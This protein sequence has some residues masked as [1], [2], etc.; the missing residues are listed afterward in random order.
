MWQSEVIDSVKPMV[1]GPLSLLVN[2][3]GSL[4]V[5]YYDTYYY[6]LRHALKTSG[7]WWVTESIKSNV[8]N[9]T[10]LGMVHD[11]AGNLHLIFNPNENVTYVTN[12][13]G[14]WTS[15]VISKNEATIYIRRIAR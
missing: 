3:D 7:L 4:H 8:I 10:S 13:T 12:A 2:P 14:T 5:A 6:R 9:V 1:S 11:A 15:E